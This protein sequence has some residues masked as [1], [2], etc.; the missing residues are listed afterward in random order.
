MTQFQSVTLDGIGRSIGQSGQ[1]SGFLLRYVRGA[2]H[3]GGSDGRIDGDVT[4][5]QGVRGVVIV[6]ASVA[7]QRAVCAEHGRYLR[8][9]DQRGDAAQ[10]IVKAV[11]L[12]GGAGERRGGNGRINRHRRARSIT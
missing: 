10:A 4:A 8:P 12:P 6:A 11:K 5:V 7:R 3:S 9:G 2:G 1:I